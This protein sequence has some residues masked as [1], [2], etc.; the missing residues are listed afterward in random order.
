MKIK[1]K[2]FS[3]LT[4]LFICFST[5]TLTSCK[6]A[7]SHLNFHPHGGGSVYVVTGISNQANYFT[8]ITIPSEYNDKPVYG[9]DG[10]AFRGC[11][12][13]KRITIPDSV[14]Y[15]GVGAFQNCTSLKSITIPDSVQSIGFLAFDG[16]KSLK[17]VTI[18]NNVRSIESSTFSRCSSLKSITIPDSV[19]SIKEDAFE[20]CGSLTTVYYTGIEEQWNNIT[21][22]NNNEWLIHA[23]II[24]KYKG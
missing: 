14:K 10:L 4:V 7:S 18:G 23:N 20:Y 15:I 21:I 24:Y 3:L 11:S 6:L 2:L 16:C 8:K 1:R 13:L 19:T 17:S 12:S 22:G 5:G 9:I